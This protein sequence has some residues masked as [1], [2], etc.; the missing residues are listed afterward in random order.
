MENKWLRVVT[1]DSLSRQ[2]TP[3]SVGGVKGPRINYNVD[4]DDVN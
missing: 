1:R 2:E 4:D 3:N